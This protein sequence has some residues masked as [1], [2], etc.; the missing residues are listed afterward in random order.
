MYCHYTE[1]EIHY[2]ASY[3]FQEPLELYLVVGE[4]YWGLNPEDDR[5]LEAPDCNRLQ[6]EGL[7]AF[8]N[9]VA[10]KVH[11]EWVA[12]TVHLE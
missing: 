7:V 1:F 12:D 4:S 5:V 9:L 10:D 2:L 8:H 6:V 3:C 11:L